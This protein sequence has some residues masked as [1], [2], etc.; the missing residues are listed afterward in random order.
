MKSWDLSAEV[1]L[2]AKQPLNGARR[3]LRESDS[4]LANLRDWQVECESSPANRGR[5]PAEL[6][7]ASAGGDGRT[8]EPC[9]KPG[10]GAAREPHPLPV[11][12]IARGRPLRAAGGLRLAG[13]P[14]A[15]NELSNAMESV[16][17]D[18]RLAQAARIGELATD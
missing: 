1:R 14:L 13:G 4:V 10:R 16:C 6:I 18:R 7:G 8:R 12:A 5:R 17:S 11:Q 15:L 3:G 9:P 2:P